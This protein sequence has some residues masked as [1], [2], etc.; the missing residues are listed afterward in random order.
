MAALKEF[1][2]DNVLVVTYWSFDD[3]LIQS[4]T[5]PYVKLIAQQLPAGS[6]IF[7]VTL[8]KTPLP[9]QTDLSGW[10]TKVVSIPYKPFGIRALFM[11]LASIWRLIRL[12]RKQKIQTIHAWCT[13]A[14]MIGYVL[15]RLTG[16]RLIIDSY[17]PHAE[18]MVENGTWSSGGVAFKVLFLFEKWQTKRAQYLIA[19][20]E[21]MRSYMKEKYGQKKANFFVK[22]ACVDLDL[23]SGAHLK[24]PVLLERLGLTG[25]I[26]CV[27]AG[28]FGGIYLDKEVFGLAKAARDLWGEQFHFLVL[29]SHTEVELLAL[30]E[31]AGFDPSALTTL[32]VPHAAVPLYLGLGDFA[33]TPVKPVPTKRYCTPIKDGEYWALGLPVIIPP[34]ISDDSDIIAAH[35]IGSIVHHF[36]PEDCLTALK[37]IDALLKSTTREDRYARIRPVAERYRNFKIAE[38][39]YA[40]IYG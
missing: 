38:E 7:L 36:T 12:I 22:P 8:D 11:W 20:T 30:S 31:D 28:K 18:A 2:V 21:G 24:D 25:K 6:R 3:A 35:K 23:F 32:F 16:K 40:A 15:S 5:L 9:Q 39:I 19:G 14:G 13:P 27:Y 4:Y 1:N 34:N 29:S 33:I 37:E 10:N 17:E 26:V